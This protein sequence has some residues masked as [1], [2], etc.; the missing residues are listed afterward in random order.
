[1]KHEKGMG[2]ERGC[3]GDGKG[4]EGGRARKGDE[5]MVCGTGVRQGVGKGRVRGTA[6]CCPKA[7]V[8]VAATAGFSVSSFATSIS[9]RSAP[10]ASCCASRSASA[11]SAAGIFVARGRRGENKGERGR[12]RY[13]RKTD[14]VGNWKE[15]HLRHWLGRAIGREPRGRKRAWGG[16]RGKGGGGARAESGSGDE[17]DP[18]AEDVGFCKRTDFE[19][20][21]REIRILPSMW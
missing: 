14:R 13:E 11:A 4:M 20:E 17:A 19:A 10:A 7:G 3:E 12:E 8:A 9:S 16:I 1:M 18:Q 21:R 6:S 15:T 5:R 2:E